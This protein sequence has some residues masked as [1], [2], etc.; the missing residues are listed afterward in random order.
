MN[1][2]LSWFSKRSAHV[3]HGMRKAI[4]SVWE[5]DPP[6]AVLPQAASA[7]RMRS[8]RAAA[9]R[10]GRGP[11]RAIAC[12]LSACPVSARPP[13]DLAREHRRG[14]RLLVTTRSGNWPSTLVL[15]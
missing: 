10:A 4:L 2:A 8:P 6:E 15:V 7:G 5:P 13:D 1:S 11:K 3:E 12:P 9:C 14:G